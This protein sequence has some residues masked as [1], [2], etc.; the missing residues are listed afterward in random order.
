MPSKIKQIQFRLPWLRKSKGENAERIAKGLLS[1]PQI[2][3][4]IEHDNCPVCGKSFDECE[5]FRV[6]DNN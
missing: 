2:R 6:L 5:Y 4:A 1:H 3:E